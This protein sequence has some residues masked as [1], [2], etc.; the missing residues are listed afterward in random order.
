MQTFEQ[1]FRNLTNKVRGKYN[2]K[3]VFL[4]PSF[5]CF[6]SCVFIVV[7]L[8]II[9]HIYVHI[10]RCHIY[11]G[12]YITLTPLQRNSRYIL[13]PQPLGQGGG[14]GSK[15]NT[16]KTD[17]MRFEQE[18]DIS[19]VKLVD[20]F[21]YLGNK[22]SS[23]EKDVKIRLGKAWNAID[24]LSIIWKSDLSDEIKRNFF[25][26]VDLSILLY[27]LTFRPVGWSCRIHRL[28]LCSKCPGWFSLVWFLC[29]MAYQPL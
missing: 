4:R 15:G 2:C 6:P 11:I 12:D 7:S 17:F 22:I 25:Q 26:A 29:L 19:T 28:H 10:C 23:T 9:L 20:Q 3:E 24:K 13:Q 16:N 14:I 27:W 1:L 21:P 8:W 5:L 18:R